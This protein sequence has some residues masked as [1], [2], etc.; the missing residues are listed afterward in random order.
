[1]TALALQPCWLSHAMLDAPLPFD[2]YSGNGT[3]LTRHGTVLSAKA[4]EALGQPLFRTR[5]DGELCDGEVAERLQDLYTDYERLLGGWTCAAQDVDALKRIAACLL[6]L[7]ATHSDVCVCL[8][9]YLVGKSHAKRHSFGVA[10]TAILLGGVLGWTDELPTLAYA[11]LTMNLS[12]LS[13]HDEWAATRGHL[14]SVQRSEVFQHPALSA[15]LLSRSP[16][17]D[18]AWLAAVEQHH[19]NLDGSGY[20]QGLV[21]EEICLEAR[22][23]RVAD[24]WCALVLHWQGKGR[25]TPGNALQV[26]SASTRGHLD[27]QVVAALR[28]LMGTHPPGTFVRLANREIALVVRWSRSNGLPCS[29]VSV[30]TPTGTVR[31]HFDTRDPGK[32]AYRIRDYT[33]LD[34]AQISRL[35]W[36]R[37]FAQAEGD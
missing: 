2:L 34:L 27:H 32:L 31:Q 23:L 14:S 15:A 1:M 37:L 13:R 16:G 3:L 30:T 18:A 28:K 8:S 24:V 20:P 5:L 33:H 17:T 35:S 10:I 19:E 25:K 36:P 29:V 11:A 7:C 4:G 22:I 26:L 9:A 12:G 6:E 21:G